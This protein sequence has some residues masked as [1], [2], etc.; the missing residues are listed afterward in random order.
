MSK[1][2][3]FNYLF[4]RH[5]FGRTSWPWFALIAGFILAMGLL[6][7]F[8]QTPEVRG[9]AVFFAIANTCILLL[10]TGENWGRDKDN[11]TK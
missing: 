5:G 10:G 3:F 1:P 4:N 9:I 8:S 7:T 2:K 6:A 11:F